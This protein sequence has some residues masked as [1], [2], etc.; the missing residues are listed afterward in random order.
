MLLSALFSCCLGLGFLYLCST[1]SLE[2]TNPFFS[3]WESIQKNDKLQSSLFL[4]F[5]GFPPAYVL[6]LFRNHDTL[7]NLHRR[8][9]FESLKLLSTEKNPE[10]KGFGLQQL[11][12]LRNTIKVYKEE[13]DNLSQGINLEGAYLRK[14]NLGGANLI[15]ANLKRANLEDAD[16]EGASLKN[17]K[18][19]MAKLRRAKLRGV[20]LINT[21]LQIAYLEDANFKDAN[22]GA[23]NLLDVIYNKSTI[24]PVGFDSKQIDIHTASIR[25]IGD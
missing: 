19:Q 10:A 16:L 18:L 3:I 2:K 12:Y 1:F 5:L 8:S 23:S 24:F 15:N 7:E 4:I 22:L 6:W 9:F 13:I 25:K 11:V 14:A 20:N 21:K 17:A